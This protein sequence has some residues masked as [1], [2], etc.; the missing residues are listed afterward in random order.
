ML[1]LQFIYYLN[2]STPR[3]ASEINFLITRR[4]VVVDFAFRRGI[5][6]LNIKK[7]N[8]KK[9]HYVSHVAYIVTPEWNFIAGHGDTCGF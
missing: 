6:E 8:N 5:C 3:E 2:E 4:S 9:Q 1:K 7:V